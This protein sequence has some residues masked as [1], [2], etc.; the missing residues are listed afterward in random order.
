MISNYALREHHVM[1]LIKKAKRKFFLKD[2]LNSTKQNDHELFLKK[3]FT[4]P[5]ISSIIFVTRF[6]G[7]LCAEHGFSPQ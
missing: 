6:P 4:I 5:E 1:L 2:S 7:A 3:N